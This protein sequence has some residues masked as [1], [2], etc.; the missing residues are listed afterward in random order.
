MKTLKLIF[1]T[2]LALMVAQ[3]SYGQGTITGSPHNFTA[4]TWNSG[5]LCKPCHTPHNAMDP[6]FKPLWNHT[7]SAQAFVIYASGIGTTMDATVGAP[8][9]S[10][11]MC[12]GCHDGTTALNAFGGAPAGA[13]VLMP[14]GPNNLGLNLTNDHPV[15]FVYNDVLASADGTL[16][17]PT[18]TASGL[19]GT[20][21]AKMLDAS[22]KVQCASCHNPHG[23]AGITKFLRK[24]NAGSALCMTCHNK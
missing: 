15:S 4:A 12:L 2:A 8:D 17:A 1:A 20:I 23:V 10:S 5:Q 19:G 24:T 22:S 14:G 21:T 18:T 7:V 13:P 9:G 3:V 11:L 6:A 16:W